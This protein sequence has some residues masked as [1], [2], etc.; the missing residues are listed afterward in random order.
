MKCEERKD[1]ENGGSEGSGRGDGVQS[2]SG[3]GSEEE[4]FF[5]SER[6]S[7]RVKVV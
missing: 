3:V 7:S 5:E 6:R 4:V 2:N 1:D